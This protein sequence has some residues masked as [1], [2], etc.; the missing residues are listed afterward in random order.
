MNIY[1]ANALSIPIYSLIAHKYYN[2]SLKNKD[3]LSNF[4]L[5]IYNFVFFLIVAQLFLTSSL[6]NYSVGS[7]ILNYRNGFESI[8]L[9]S[10]S[11]LSSFKW[12]LGYLILNKTVSLFT[13]N[14][15]VL[16]FIM[17]FAILS[18]ISIYI[19]TNSKI[20]W[21]S[22]Y[23]FITMGFFN[24]TLSGYRQSIAIAITVYSVK[25]IKE[26]KFL[27]FLSTVTM[28]FLFHKSAIVF[29]PAYFLSKVRINYKH[30]VAIFIFGTIVLF[31]GDIIAEF[32]I[33]IY[34]K[35][36]SMTKGEGYN[37]FAM[38]LFIVLSAIYVYFKN[39][40]NDKN[41]NLFLNL[42]ITATFLQL[43]SFNLS[44]FVR[45]VSYFSIHMIVLIPNTINCIPNKKTKNAALMITIIFT[46][47]FFVYY[48]SNNP[49]DTLPYLFLWQ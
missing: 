20:S 39:D 26:K 17:S 33:S 44:I 28:A 46:A 7:D 31:F 5:R 43:F 1:I 37:L 15:H 27:L 4:D 34:N 16:I 2:Y 24:F 45:V 32:F 8:S 18:L 13:M 47:I 25:F 48:L 35:N 22:L 10:W 41:V 19:Y 21:L 6:K 40:K 12:E 36:Y 3:K 49:Y 29:V 30:L 42:M 9:L 11:E 14:F 23:L 38:F